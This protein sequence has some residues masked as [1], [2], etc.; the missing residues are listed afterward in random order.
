MTVSF[1]SKRELVEGTV[2]AYHYDS[3]VIVCEGAEG[4]RVGRRPRGGHVRPARP[5]VHRALVRHA[6]RAPALSAQTYTVDVGVVGAPPELVQQLPGDGVPEADQGAARGCRGESGAAPADAHAHQRRAVA[7]HHA[8][9]AGAAVAVH[10]RHVEQLQG[11]GAVR[12]RGQ[13]LRRVGFRGDGAQRPRGGRRP[14]QRD[15][16]ERR[17]RQ[18]LHAGRQ[19]NGHL[20]FPG[21]QR[22]YR[23]LEDH[24]SFEGTLLVVQQ[25][26]AVRLPSFHHE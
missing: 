24:L 16:L 22:S 11:S 8:R 9:R 19:D 25:E 2:F 21:P 15:P 17:Q 1:R 3:A 10:A 23:R 6:H 5:H 20:I 4:A 12:G 18:H 13:Y 14:Q 7:A 26:E